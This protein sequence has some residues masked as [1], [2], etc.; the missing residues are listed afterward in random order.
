[1]PIQFPQPRI[2]NPFDRILWQ[3]GAKWPQQQNNPNLARVGTPFNSDTLNPGFWRPT[4]GV[5]PNVRNLGKMYQ[6]GE[7]SG[8]LPNPA[9][10]WQSAVTISD[11]VTVHLVTRTLGTSRMT[12]SGTSR[13]SAGATLGLCQVLVFRTEDKSFVAET[14]SDASGAWSIDLLVGGPFFLVEYK[15][16]SPDVSGTSLN[17]LAPVPS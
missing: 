14:T 2:D 3:R 4:G 15:A 6:H 5:R 12:L 17:N 8:S 1:M 7:R 16:G 13:D 9:E 10:H 11:G